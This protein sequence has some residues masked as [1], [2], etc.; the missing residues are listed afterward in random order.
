[1]QKTAVLLG[2][3]GRKR[4]ELKTKLKDIDEERSNGKF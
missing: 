4:S 3:K 1:M 2:K